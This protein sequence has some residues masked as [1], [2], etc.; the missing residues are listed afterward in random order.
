MKRLN[1]HR[2]IKGTHSMH[3]H[4]YL[5]WKSGDLE[6]MLHH[7]CSIQLNKFALR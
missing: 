7:Y 6:F 1:F 3:T 5:A 2:V 4:V